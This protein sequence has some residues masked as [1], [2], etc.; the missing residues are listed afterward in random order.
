M[1]QRSTTRRRLPIVLLGTLLGL[2]PIAARAEEDPFGG[3]LFPPDLVLRHRI[4]LGIDAGQ[5]EAIKAEIQR[6]QPLFLD[7]QLELQ[8]ELGELRRRVE[9][10]RPDEAEVLAQL[11]RVLELERE[12]KR[13]QVGL[14][15]RI[16]ALLDPGQQERLRGLRGKE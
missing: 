12:I 8:S 13:A 5:I 3:A 10:E 2:G 6:V 1:T 15:V 7:W 11:D 4:E 9:Q 16:K 14:L